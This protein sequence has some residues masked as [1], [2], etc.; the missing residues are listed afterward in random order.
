MELTRSYKLLKA[1]KA[2]NGLILAAPSDKTGYSKVWIRDNIYVSLGVELLDKDAALKVIHGLFDIFRKHENKIDWAIKEKPKHAFQ[3]IHARYHPETLEEYHEEWG[4]KQND[5]VGAFLFRAADLMNKGFPVIRDEQDTRILN[6]LV[7]YLGSIEYWQ[8]PDNGVWEEYE[9]VHA[10]SVGAC[11]AGLKAI[12]KYVYVPEY[13][14]TFGQ[15][16]LNSLLPRESITKETDLALLSLIYPYN[17][18]TPE[19]TA[20]VLYNV[21]KELIRTRGVLRYKGD[22]YY[23][24]GGEAEWTMGF[25]WLA[26]IYKML[27]NHRK[28]FEYMTKTIQC[29]ND[30]GEL[31]ELYYSNSEEHN[32][33]SPLGW[34]ES[35]YIVAAL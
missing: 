10:S 33:N 18:L 15:N 2:K 32:D 28:Y 8:D 25:P 19:Q 27:G 16:T 22:K 35:L 23:N 6:K 9:E 34:S 1:L 12:S 30:K 29:I 4:N 14:I 20:K 26:I 11:L 5:A 24:I 13:L 3:Y 7:S 21:E 17:L 31:P